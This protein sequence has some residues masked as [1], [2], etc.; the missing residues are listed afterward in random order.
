MPDQEQEIIIVP[1]A[2]SFDSKYHLGRP[3]QVHLRHSDSCGKFGKSEVETTA[4]RLV[5]FMKERKADLWATFTISELKDFY[6]SNNWNP[7]TIFDGLIGSWIDLGDMMPVLYE[8]DVF[9]V[10]LLGG[11]FCV[12]KEFIERCFK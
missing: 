1:V 6:K 10:N 11:K 4:G 12:T 7:N 8:T 3:S 5:L 9:L 2:E